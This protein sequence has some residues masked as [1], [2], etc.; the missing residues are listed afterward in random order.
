VTELHQ[1]IKQYLTVRR[2]M[3]FDLKRVELLLIQFA[4]YLAE[5]DQIMITTEAA[6]AW[7]KLPVDADPSWWSLRLSAVRPLARYLH[8]LNP[9]HEVP[10]PNLLPGSSHRTVPYPFSDADIA[11]LLKKARGL[12]SEL[13]AITMETLIGL[14]AVTGLRIGEALRL[15][16]DDV[17][18][19]DATVLIAN[20]K[21]G[22]T[23]Q[24][25]LSASAVDALKHYKYR[26]KKLITRTTEP[27]LFLSSV[28]NRLLYSSFHVS[29]LELINQAKLMPCASSGSPR[30]HDLRH[31]FAV[32]TLLG[33]YRDG[34]DVNAEMSVLSTFLGHTHPR[35]TCWYLWA[36]PE[37]MELVA[38]R[39]D[40]AF[41]EYL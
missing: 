10:P 4:D 39:V 3:G 41:G 15:N 26:R 30:P 11:T 22:K 7:A 18:L 21:F 5:N 31:F 13:R 17:D 14:L 34:V 20:T 27:A 12:R 37:L 23:R 9:G 1:A 38:T 19:T 29:W 33:W 8:V 28:G 36:A 35:H 24:V 40:D 32:S 2:A 25:P 6:L 16:C